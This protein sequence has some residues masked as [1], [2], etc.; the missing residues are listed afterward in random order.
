M[1]F[2]VKDINENVNKYFT[3]IETYIKYENSDGNFDINKYCEEFF[4]GLMNIA[5]KSNLVNLNTLK[6]NFPAV[7]L[8]DAEE[9]I[10]YQVTTTNSKKKIVKTIE[11]F[12]KH[13]LNNE[14]SELYILILGTKVK[15]QTF[16]DYK[17]FSFSNV[18][19]IDLTDLS[20]AIKKLPIKRREKVVNYM[21]KRINITTGKPS[22]SDSL[23]TNKVTY[24]INMNGYFNNC[25]IPQEDRSDVFD[26]YKNFINDL[27]KFD[28]DTRFVIYLIFR[29]VHQSNYEGIEFDYREL[30]GQLNVDRYMVNEKLSILH[31]RKIVDPADET[32]SEFDILIKYYNDFDV[33]LDLKNYCDE[34][35]VDYRVPLLELDF[36]FLD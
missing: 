36:S 9:G 30:Y 16:D 15:N 28:N 6:M 10:C 31:K 17:N 18:N 21:S 5:F 32:G 22:F 1:M 11:K 24:P 4:C 35:E 29:S 33:Y 34:A 20:K 8:G 7:D 12:I 26:A 25:D 23:I 27:S 2:D 3:M 13:G 14:Y 19:V